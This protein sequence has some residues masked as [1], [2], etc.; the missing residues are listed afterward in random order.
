MIEREHKRLL[1]PVVRWERPKLVEAI[2]PNDLDAVELF[3]ERR[4][5]LD[6]EVRTILGAL[7]DDFLKPMSRYR[8]AC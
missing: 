2:G 8:I 5:L 3:E 6:A 1:E 4:S 7:T